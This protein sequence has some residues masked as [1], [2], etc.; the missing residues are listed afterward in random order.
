MI[1]STVA[2][3]LGVIDEIPQSIREIRRASGFEYGKFD[4]TEVDGEVIVY[5]MNKTPA[6]GEKLIALMPDSNRKA[7]ADQILSYG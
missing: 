5:D 4:Y 1:K 2:T 3:D 6:L 7:L